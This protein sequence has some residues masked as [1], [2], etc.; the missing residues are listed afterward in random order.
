[1]QISLGEFLSG[2]ILTVVGL[3]K[4]AYGW[5]GAENTKN[6][7]TPYC[8]DDDAVFLNALSL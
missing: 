8:A 2:Q 1:M 4:I 5:R 7:V 6:F 3:E